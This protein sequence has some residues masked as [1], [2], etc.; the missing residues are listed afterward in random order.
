MEAGKNYYFFTRVTYSGGVNPSSRDD[1]DE[2]VKVEAI[3]FSSKFEVDTVIGEVPLGV[4]LPINPNLLRMRALM[5]VSLIIGILEMEQPLLKRAQLIFII[6][7]ELI[8]Q[9]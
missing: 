8:R 7:W 9:D 6:I 5:Q 2:Y 4:F 3:D 1:S